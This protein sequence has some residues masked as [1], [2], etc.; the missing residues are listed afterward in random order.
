LVGCDVEAVGSIEQIPFLPIEFFKGRE[1]IS[2]DG[3]SELIFRSSGTKDGTQ[4]QHFVY[5]K[6]I[7]EKVF[8]YS[9]VSRAITLFLDYFRL[10][11]SE[12]D[13]HS[14]TWLTT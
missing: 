7:C 2:F 5:K 9:T 10:I 14:S 11:S 13:L 6:N 12:R 3:K 8:S 4:S 1:I